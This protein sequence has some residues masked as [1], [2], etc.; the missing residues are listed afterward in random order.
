LLGLGHCRICKQPAV[1]FFDHHLLDPRRG[2]RRTSFLEYFRGH[3]HDQC[4]W[5]PI[6]RLEELLPPGFN[7]EPAAYDPAEV[8][9]GIRIVFRDFGS[10]FRRPEALIDW[11]W[12]ARCSEASSS[13]QPGD[14]NGRG[15]GSLVS[16]ASHDH[17]DISL[18]AK[19]VARQGSRHPFTGQLHLK[20]SHFCVNMR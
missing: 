17:G 15:M 16:D 13:S 7:W 3:D 5:G 19:Q 2:R 4:D 1:F 18:P 9:E 6:C 14:R 10:E 8:A 11:V 12:E 20:S